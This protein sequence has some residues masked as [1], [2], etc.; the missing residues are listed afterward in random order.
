MA[1]FPHCL[2]SPFEQGSGLGAGAWV[3]GKT[4]GGGIQ[5][6]LAGS[7]MGGYGEV[8]VGGIFLRASQS[9]GGDFGLCPRAPYGIVLVLRHLWA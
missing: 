1:S 4:L 7:L 2:S 9:D 8:D 5:S 6:A 3:L